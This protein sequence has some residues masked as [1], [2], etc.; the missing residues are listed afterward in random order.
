MTDS[1]SFVQRL[2]IMVFGV[3]AV[4]FLLA[5]AK[6]SY[7]D[8]VVY[9]NDQVINSKV[10][11]EIDNDIKKTTVFVDRYADY[12][13]VVRVLK[14]NN[15]DKRQSGDAILFEVSP[16][17]AAEVEEIRRDNRN[18]KLG[19]DDQLLGASDFWIGD[20]EVLQVNKD[21]TWAW[22]QTLSE[23]NYECL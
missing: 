20:A 9:K 16:D 5:W 14:T 8:G 21:C 7:D 11:K 17:A 4:Y 1:L 12:D 13:F 19:D 6:H 23:L 15:G 22:Y 10:A 2:L 3:V 18:S